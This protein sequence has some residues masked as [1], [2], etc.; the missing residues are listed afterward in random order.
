MNKFSWFFV[1]QN[2]GTFLGNLWL[3]SRGLHKN[4]SAVLSQQ[5]VNSANVSRILLLNVSM[6]TKINIVLN[7]MWKHKCSQLVLTHL[8]HHTEGNSIICIWLTWVTT[9]KGISFSTLDSAVSDSP[10]SPYWS[11]LQSLP[12]VSDSPGSPHWRELQPYHLYL[13]HLGHHTEGNSS[14]TICIWLT[15][16]TILKGTPVSVI[17]ANWAQQP[18]SSML[19]LMLQPAEGAAVPLVGVCLETAQ[20][21]RKRTGQV[22]EDIWRQGCEVVVVQTNSGNWMKGIQRTLL[23]VVDVVPAQI[24]SSQSYQSSEHSRVQSCELVVFQVETGNRHQALESRFIQRGNGV[25]P[26]VKPF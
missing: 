3:K 16:V 12:S 10:G 17:C 8:S 7:I 20:L 14:P 13:T 21:K 22:Y 4:L 11:E 19:L 15:W 2:R 5:K 24:K 9:L 25:V 26:Q 1:Q 18:N 23:N 6:A